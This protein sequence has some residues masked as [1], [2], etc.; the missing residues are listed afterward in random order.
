MLALRLCSALVLLLQFSSGSEEVPLKII[1]NVKTG[2]RYGCE[3]RYGVPLDVGKYGILENTDG[4]NK[5]NGWRGN[6]I[7]SLY[8]TDGKW[9]YRLVPKNEDKSLPEDKNGALPQVC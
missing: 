2:G 6:V 7:T 3:Q 8:Q 1:W 9:P 4:P 5:F